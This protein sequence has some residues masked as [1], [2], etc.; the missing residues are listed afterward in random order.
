[1]NRTR[2]M[3]PPLHICC[4]QSGQS[5]APSSR[6]AAAKKILELDES[7]YGGVLVNMTTKKE[8]LTPLM[9]AAH[10]NQID[11]MELLI[12]KKANLAQQCN[13]RGWTALH[14][15][16]VSSGSR[17]A[18]AVELLLKHMTKE[19]VQLQSKEFKQTALICAAISGDPTTVGL[20]LKSDKVDAY[21]RDVGG[22][23]A[24]HHAVRKSSPEKVSLLLSSAEGDGNPGYFDENGVNLTILDTAILSLIR[25]REQN[26]E[27][28]LRASQTL[29]IVYDKFG[30][31]RDLSQYRF[32]RD[33]TEILIEQAIA[34][35]AEKPAVS[36][37]N[38]RQNNTTKWTHS[39]N[40]EDA[41]QKLEFP[42]KCPMLEEQTAPSDIDLSDYKDL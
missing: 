39:S 5:H 32:V 6:L 3:T 20:L 29:K 31:E 41:T 12:S 42:L 9:V 37:Y 19:Q 27:R 33:I 2:R 17:V 34:S 36:H 21:N 8:G 28:F 15:A 35:V 22:D 14:Y 38:R 7:V 25:A 16:V 1:M 10:H 26:T 13:A 4:F 11:L 40:S 18:D 23:Y 30:Y 24:L